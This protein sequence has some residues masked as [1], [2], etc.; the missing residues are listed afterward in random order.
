[1]SEAYVR[2]YGTGRRAAPRVAGD[3][4]R[5]AARRRAHGM[6]ERNAA[7]LARARAAARRSRVIADDSG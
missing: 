6:V 7:R 5:E 1:M 2:R 3:A 4:R